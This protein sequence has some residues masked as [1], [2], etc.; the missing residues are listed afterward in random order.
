MRFRTTGTNILAEESW[1]NGNTWQSL[2]GSNVVTQPNA[3]LYI[4]TFF[5][6]GS[7]IA[8]IRATGVTLNPED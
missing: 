2:M 5:G 8:N 6:E 1:D 4:K 7:S 3:R